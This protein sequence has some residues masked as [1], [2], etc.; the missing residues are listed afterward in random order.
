MRIDRI[1]LRSVGRRV[2][3]GNSGDKS[4]VNGGGWSFVRIFGEDYGFE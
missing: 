4:V 2:R 3:C 1:R